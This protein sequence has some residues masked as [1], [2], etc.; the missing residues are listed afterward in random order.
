MWRNP[1]VKKSRAVVTALDGR[2]QVLVVRHG[3][4]DADATTQAEACLADDKSMHTETGCTSELLTVLYCGHRAKQLIYNMYTELDEVH[5]AYCD[6]MIYE[7]TVSPK[8][9]VTRMPRQRFACQSS[10]FVPFCFY[11]VQHTN[12]T[13]H[14]RGLSKKISIFPAKEIPQFRETLYNSPLGRSNHVNDT[15]N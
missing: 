1:G 12:S 15:K 13:A 2:S 6:S 4:E 3:I 14:A 10:R 9:G 7:T 8:A 11:F 5:V